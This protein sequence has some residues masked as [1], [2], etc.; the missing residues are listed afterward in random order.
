VLLLDEATSALDAQ[1]ERLVQA[2]IDKLQQS[3][4]QTTIVIAHRLSTIRNADKIAVVAEG[5]IA[6]LGSHD[7]LMNKNGIYADLVLLQVSAMAPVAEELDVIAENEEG[8]EEEEE[9]GDEAKDGEQ[10]DEGNLTAVAVAVDD[11][12]AQSLVK[13]LEEEKDTPAVAAV[14]STPLDKKKK[15]GKQGKY[16]HSK[17]KGSANKEPKTKKEEET[18]K[19]DDLKKAKSQVWKLVYRYSHWLAMSIVGAAIFGAIFPA[20]GL[21]LAETQNVFYYTDPA[22]LRRTVSFLAGMFCIMGVGAIISSILEFYGIA[23]VRV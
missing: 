20:W 15:H 7:E 14:V 19:S 12:E 17:D 8:E 9:E 21:L 6:E 22:E 3:K 5:L 11:L 4:S 2:S 18:I 1:S 23:E 10:D 13:P 16:H